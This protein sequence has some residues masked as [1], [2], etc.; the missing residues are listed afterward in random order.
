MIIATHQP[1]FRPW[2]G[3]FD[4]MQKYN[5]FIIKD[6]VQ[7]SYQDFLNR[8]NFKDMNY[9]AEYKTVFA[10]YDLRHTSDKCELFQTRIESSTIDDL[11]HAF[12]SNPNIPSKDTFI[13][14]LKVKLKAK[15]ELK[16][17]L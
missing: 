5:L 15:M 9:N 4:K 8:Y 12:R 17:E 1:N 10:I 13:K 14:K 16:L 2:L 3:F 6:M 7:F 11:F